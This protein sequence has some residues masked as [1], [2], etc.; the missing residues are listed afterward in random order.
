MLRDMVSFSDKDYLLKAHMISL[1]VEDAQSAMESYREV[2]FYERSFGFIPK[3]K[4]APSK[5]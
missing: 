1:K 4:T 2:W 3:E 5:R